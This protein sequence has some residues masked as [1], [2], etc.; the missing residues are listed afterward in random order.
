MNPVTLRSVSIGTGIP[1]ICL[2][3]VGA[4][5]AD[6]LH[7]AS[8][9]ASYPHDIVEWR[10]DWFSASDDLRQVESCAV[11]LRQI[12]G[13]IPLLFTFRTKEEGGQCSI[14]DM[15]YIRLNSFVAQHHLA[16]ALDVELFRG[17]EVVRTIVAKA[18]TNHTAVVISNH[19][20]T[21]TPTQ[22]E[23]VSRLQRA[24][25]LGGDILKIAVMPQNA[26]D[27][28]TL[29]AATEQAHRLCVQP[30][31]TMSMGQQGMISRVAGET[32]GSAV[33]F[34]AA[35]VASAPGQMPADALEQILRSL[36]GAQEK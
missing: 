28:I 31:I 22:E 10:V 15:D 6:I 14:S 32:F 34:G 36:H 20:F 25:Q 1:K 11:A 7:Q 13:Q 30:L 9:L 33:T 3:I 23:I 17:N 16:D 19:N 5:K 18:H 12:L 27:V 26:Q 8:A 24:E 21:Q 29:L 4:S 2:P 35:G